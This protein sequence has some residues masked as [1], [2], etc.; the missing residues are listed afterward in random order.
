MRKIKRVI[1]YVALSTD[2][3]VGF[4]DETESDHAASVDLMRTVGYD[5]AFLFAYSRRDKTYAARHYHDNVSPADKVRRLQELISVYRETLESKS[6][7][8]VGRRH[9]VLV[10]GPAKRQGET[11]WTGRTCGNR[12]VVFPRA[13][14]LRVPDHYVRGERGDRSTQVT[15]PVPVQVGDYVAVEITGHATSTLFGDVVART[16]ISEF[17]GRHGGATVGEREPEAEVG[18]R[19]VVRDLGVGG[20]GRVPSLA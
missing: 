8:E 4:C 7:R 12:R 1:P 2:M 14:D 20:L 10:E 11:Q 18:T 5:Q 15:V 19:A 3:I 17:V 6:A 9:L 13:D 16:T